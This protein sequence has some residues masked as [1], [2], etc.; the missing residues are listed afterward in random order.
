MDREEEEKME[1]ASSEVRTV[2]VPERAA[3]SKASHPTLDHLVYG[4]L[5]EAVA[6][7]S[8]I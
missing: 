2:D 4:A 7:R 6:Q 3:D 5:R 8:H 1:S